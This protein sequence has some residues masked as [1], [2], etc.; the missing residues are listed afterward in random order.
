MNMRSV[1]GLSRLRTW[2]FSGLLAAFG[3]AA[4]SAEA[5]TVTLYWHSLDA[6]TSGTLVLS[7]TTITNLNQNN[8]TVNDTLANLKTD[9]T[10]FSYTN[11]SGTFSSASGP[12][13]LGGASTNLATF[14]SQAVLQASNPLNLPVPSGQW[15]VTNGV[16][17][18]LFA[19][20]AGST[21]SMSGTGNLLFSS[22]GSGTTAAKSGNGS[23]ALTNAGSLTFSG[24]V[25]QGYW[26]TTAVPLPAAGWLFGSGIAALAGLRRR[27][28]ATA[29][30][31]A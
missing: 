20:E 2:A 8:F 13:S 15:N 21:F 12:W 14:A 26:S 16:L 25:A 11:A 23:F 27:R 24:T 7:S 5:G 31:S 30:A 18:S 22:G 9:I 4:S 17:T 29:V 3:L 1:H 19:I 10:S 6:S 28:G